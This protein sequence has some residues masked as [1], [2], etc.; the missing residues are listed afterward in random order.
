M[1]NG[2]SSR[3]AGGKVEGGSWRLGGPKEKGT[4]LGVSCQHLVPSV[5]NNLQTEST[6]EALGG[7]TTPLLCPPFGSKNTGPWGALECSRVK[8]QGVVPAAGPGDGSQGPAVAAIFQVHNCSS[9]LGDA[10]AQSLGLWSQPVL[11]SNV[12]AE[13][14]SSFHL[15]SPPSPVP[16]PH[17][18]LPWEGMSL[19]PE[20][21]LLTGASSSTWRGWSSS[22]I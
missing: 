1:R 22:M 3:G 18:R 13:Q 7:E 14:R 11:E 20:P 6:G 19:G 10:I 21:G 9:W 17:Q 5:P 4:G 16:G 15:P 12:A 2:A 8:G